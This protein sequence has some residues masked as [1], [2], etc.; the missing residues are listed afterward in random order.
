LTEKFIDPFV[1]DTGTLLSPS[2]MSD[3]LKIFIFVYHN[4][5]EEQIN[6]TDIT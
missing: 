1:A 4:M 3:L 2:Q 6:K 5:V